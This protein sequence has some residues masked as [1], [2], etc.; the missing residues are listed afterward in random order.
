M[1]AHRFSSFTIV[2]YASMLQKIREKSEMRPENQVQQHVAYGNMLG[3]GAGPRESQSRLPNGG[4]AMLIVSDFHDYYDHAAVYGVDKTVVYRRKREVVQG[5]RDLLNGRWDWG[6]DHHTFRTDNDQVCNRVY[7]QVLG[8]C[9][10]LYPFV[11]ATTDLGLE[12]PHPVFVFTSEE[13]GAWLS[14]LS[15]PAFRWSFDKQDASKYLQQDF[16]R[17]R[18]FFLQHKTPLFLH[19]WRW[20]GWDWSERPAEGDLLLN[21]CLKDIE[22]TRFKDAPTAFQDIYMYISGVLGVP[23]NATVELSDAIRQAKHG[24]DGKYSFRKPPG[25]KERWR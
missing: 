2:L 17:F 25:K 9:G 3:C 15:R 6:R 22:F 1:I 21:P 20:S 7:L 16:S 11:R 10:A 23:A 5:H 14:G 19:T 18:E 4:L 12:D 8:Y 13:F 24:H